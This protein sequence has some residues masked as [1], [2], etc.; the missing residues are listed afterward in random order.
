[1]A[2][3]E[4]VLD[5]QNQIQ[6]TN[7][8]NQ[9]NLDNDDGTETNETKT[10]S[11]A[12]VDLM[13]REATSQGFVKG[14]MET[15]SK[16]EKKAAEREKA[17]KEAAEKQARF[18]KMSELEKA[19]TGEKEAKLELQQLRDQIALNEQREETR[20]YMKDKDVPDVFVDALLVP[21]DA[22][23]TLQ[24]VD[25]FKK[26]FEAEVQKRVEN[27]V[28]VHIPKQNTKDEKN[29]GIDPYARLGVKKL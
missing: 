14:K 21:K 15:N 18:E 7:N 28:Q 29:F 26:L 19:Q 24:N 2:E 5:G 10:Y 17:A 22:E 13:L 6:D 3:N 4:Q 11:Q 27:R 20:K 25:E 1:M 12:E 8:Q 9:E 23:L 16:W